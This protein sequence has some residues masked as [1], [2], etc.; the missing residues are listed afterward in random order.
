MEFLR[1][2]VVYSFVYITNAVALYISVEILKI[3]PRPAQLILLP[4][5]TLISFFGQKLWTF[6][7][8]KQ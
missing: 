6:K 4:I 3:D 5:V 1:F 8:K 7:V 2:N